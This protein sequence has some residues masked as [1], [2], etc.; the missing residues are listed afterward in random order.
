MEEARQIYSSLCSTLGENTGETI[1]FGLRLGI[2]ESGGC[3][4]LA[5]APLEDACGRGPLPHDCASTASPW[6]EP[7]AVKGWIGR[8]WRA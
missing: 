4:A 6:K 1:L 5:N 8:C 2:L 3:R 7:G